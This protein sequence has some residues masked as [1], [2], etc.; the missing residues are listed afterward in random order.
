MVSSVDVGHQTDP[1]ARREF[2]IAQLLHLGQGGA[3][4]QVGEDPGL[5]VFFP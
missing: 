5:I 1:A 2:L 3:V 4:G